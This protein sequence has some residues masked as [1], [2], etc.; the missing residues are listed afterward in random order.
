MATSGTFNF[1][2][3]TA[4]FL[5]NAYALCGIK[6]TELL[7]Q[8]MED[9]RFHANLLLAEWSNR[10]VNLWT[11]DL[12]TETLVEG[13]ATYNVD[14]E[15]ITILDAYIR[16]TP[17]GGDPI[18]RL[19]FPIS[20]SD[21]AALPDKDTEAP[22]TTYWFDR[23]IAPTIT[24]WQVPDGAGPYELR[25]YFARQIEDATLPS[26]TTMEIPYR[27]FDA[28]NWGLA[29]RLAV[30]YAPQSAAPLD[31]RAERAW[32]IAAQQDTERVPL[33]LSPGLAGY[34]R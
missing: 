14:P 11:V 15:V 30:I 18:D 17:S 20:R 21:Y 26:G 9:G 12:A 13:T 6:R 7:Q 2:P 31:A 10:Q 32:Q 24:L 33:Y 4:D 3:S 23:L 25:Y 34:F 29:A 28:F 22:P 5:L 1:N 27:W 19:I 16:I 8:H